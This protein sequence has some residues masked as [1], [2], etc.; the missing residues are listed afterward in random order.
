MEHVRV[1]IVWNVDRSCRSC[2]PQGGGI[3]VD[4]HMTDAI[5]AEG[6]FD[7][8]ARETSPDSDCYFANCIWDALGIPAMLGGVDARIETRCSDCGEALAVEVQ[9]HTVRGD[10]QV[11]HF[12]V[13]AARWWDDIVF[14]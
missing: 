7:Q 5:R 4:L 14:T 13:P 2:N 3:D 1:E 10:S 9:D 6:H 12:A 8:R 11:V